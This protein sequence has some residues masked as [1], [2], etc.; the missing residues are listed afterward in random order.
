MDITNNDHENGSSTTANHEQLFKPHY[1]RVSNRIFKDML[2]NAISDGTIIK[3][4]LNKNE[5]LQLIRQVTEIVNNLYY[6]DLQ[7]QLWREYYNLGMKEGIWRSNLSKLFAKQHHTC[8]SCGFAK[9]IVEERQKLI[10]QQ[11]TQVATELGRVSMQLQ[12]EARNW[13]PAVDMNILSDAINR[14]VIRAQRR[15]REEFVYK[16]AIIVFDSNDHQSIQKFYDSHPN[17]E[18]VSSK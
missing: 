14:C 11:R 1:L 5:K 15:L 3:Q 2:S 13:Q 8:H 16:K 18:Q 7:L 9:H 6:I 17:G 4:C 12:S 10:T